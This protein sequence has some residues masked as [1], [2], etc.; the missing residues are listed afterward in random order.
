MMPRKL[1]F[2]ITFDEG[3]TEEGVD[4]IRDEIVELITEEWKEDVTAVHVVPEQLRL[5]FA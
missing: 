4:A 3:I 2:V 5:T 1:H